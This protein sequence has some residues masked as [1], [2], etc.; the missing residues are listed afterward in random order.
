MTKRVA[1]IE[2]DSDMRLPNIPQGKCINHPTM[3]AERLHLCP[4]CLAK[5]EKTVL[6]Y[7]A[8]QQGEVLSPD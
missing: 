4:L 3:K 7:E 8:I 5:W 6:D 1:L 2:R